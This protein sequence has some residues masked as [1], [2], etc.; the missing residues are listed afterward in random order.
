MI[1]TKIVGRCLSALTL[2]CGVWGA[3]AQAA[4]QKRC[5]IEME[6]RAD[7]SLASSSTSWRSLFKHQRT[8]GSC[9]DG[10]IAEGYSNAVVGLFAQKWGRFSE[11]VAMS[12]RHPAFGRWVLRHIDATANDDELKRILRHADHCVDNV[13]MK[14]ECKAVGQA[15]ADALAEWKQFQRK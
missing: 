3:P 6:M 11:Y 15:A 10:S 4:P 13:K 9:D 1:W 5:P 12:R 7:A 14:A 2:I 8:F